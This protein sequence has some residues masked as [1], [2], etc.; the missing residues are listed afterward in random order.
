MRRGDPGARRQ[1]LD[2]RHCIAMAKV[3]ALAQI[4]RR[5]SGG[6]RVRTCWRLRTRRQKGGLARRVARRGE[7]ARRLSEPFDMVEAAGIE[8]WATE[9]KSNTYVSLV[10]NLCPKC[11]DFTARRIINL[12][13]PPTVAAADHAPIF[14]TH[15]LGHPK[16]VLAG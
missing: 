3:A 11:H 7:R 9:P 1:W 2:S 13:N 15:L 5:H 8:P 14:V 12:G 10:P 16:S 4:H 6:S